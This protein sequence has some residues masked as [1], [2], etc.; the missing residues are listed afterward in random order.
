[1]VGG[2]VANFCFGM[3][4]EMFLLNENRFLVVKINENVQ[5]ALLANMGKRM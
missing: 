4:G 5:G 3:R 2:G 1:M